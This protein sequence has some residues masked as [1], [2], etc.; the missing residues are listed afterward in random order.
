MVV[1][2]LALLAFLYSF[3]FAD[4]V[5]DGTTAGADCSADQSALTAS[6]ERADNGSA[7]CR[8][9]NDLGSGVVAVVLL[10]LFALGAVVRRLRDALEKS[11]VL[12]C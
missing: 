4:L 12:C 10:G 9:A 8:A 1:L 3:I 5:G 7:S 2:A 11:V 6:G